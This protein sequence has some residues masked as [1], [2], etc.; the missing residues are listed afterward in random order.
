MSTGKVAAQVAHGSMAFLINMIR[1]STV[2]INDGYHP[3]WIYDRDGSGNKRPHLYRR[4]DLDRFAE[5]A[6]NNGKDGFYCELVD[7]SNPYGTLRLCDA[8]YHCSCRMRIDNDLYENWI[9]GEFTKIV[10]QARNK[11]NLLR[12]KT[13]AEEMNMFEG[14]DFFC[15]YD[16]CKTELEPEEIDKSGIGRTLTCIGF[17]PMPEEVIDK[18]GR[19]YHLYV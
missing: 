13:M 12:A 14:E 17:R 3:A 16:S 5:Q 9:N 18:I 1:D 4:T 7:P 2:K 19:R 8:K 6:R 10:L 15:I 11:S